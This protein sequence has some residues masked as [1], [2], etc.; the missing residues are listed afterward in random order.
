MRREQLL[1][2]VQ[3]ADIAFIYDPREN[4]RWGLLRGLPALRYL[5]VWDF[6]YPTSWC[7]FNRGDRHF[8]MDYQYHVVS[9]ALDI[10][11]DDPDFGVITNTYYEQETQYTIKYLVNRYTMS[12]NTLFVLTDSKQFEPQGAKRPLYQD[13]D[14]ELVGTYS[15]VYAE[16]AETYSEA[17]WDLPLSDTK[18]LFL[19]DN[20]NLYH[21][22]TDDTVTD[23]IELFEILPEAPF[24]PLYDALTSVFSRP[25]EL[26][27]VP[28]DADSGRPEL[29]R[30]LR[31]RIEWDRDTAQD[32]AQNLNE[33]VIDD[34]STFDGAAA[35][36][37]PSVREA[38]LAGNDLDVDSSSI[39][40]RYAG[41]LQRHKL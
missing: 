27:T 33:S 10:P 31:R 2:Q 14:V 37:S 40:K 38:R 23:T 6:T 41:W 28:L 3:D 18:N 26:G 24:L 16:F 11:D 29:V 35:R 17:G 13:P 12:A 22:V 9:N 36:R 4:S 8:E 5:D 39:N 1:S 19:Q 30:W 34:G 15:D 7:Q 32:I 20:A 21:Y 25:T